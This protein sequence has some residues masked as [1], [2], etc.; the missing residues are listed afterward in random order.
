MSKPAPTPTR[1]R[2]AT[3]LIEGLKAFWAGLS[4][5]AVIDAGVG[6]FI[7]VVLSILLLRDYQRTPIE[8]LPPGSVA[9]KDIIAPDDL[10]IEDV[11]ETKSLRDQAAASVLPVF[12]FNV[13]SGRDSINS[14]E[15]LFVIGREA[16]V[17]ASP[18][19]LHDKFEEEVGIPLDPDQITL[20]K[21][22][23]FSTELE[24]LMTE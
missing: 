8:Q 11:G 4:D 10:K 15:Q 5:Q 18:E 14:L 2:L 3:K 12:D 9:T 7:I 6:L 20:L 24:R 17:D 21:K 19:D 23:R 16:P 22:H 1:S 13:R